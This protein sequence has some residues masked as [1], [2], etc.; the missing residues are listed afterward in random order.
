[1]SLID[2]SHGWQYPGARDELRFLIFE[3][4]AI[5]GRLRYSSSANARGKTLGDIEK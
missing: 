3:D 1:M 4:D 5:V 2:I